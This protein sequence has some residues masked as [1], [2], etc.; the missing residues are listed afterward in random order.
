MRQEFKRK[1]CDRKRLGCRN[2]DGG[3]VWQCQ[4]Y[5]LREGVR[6]NICD[7]KSIKELCRNIIE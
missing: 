7:E 1:A 2:H 5:I 4:R 6:E 3:S